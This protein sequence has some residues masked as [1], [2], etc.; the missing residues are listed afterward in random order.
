L[1]E[2]RFV[3][4]ALKSDVGERGQAVSLTLRSPSEEASRTAEQSP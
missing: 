2:Q 4:A 3:H 1:L